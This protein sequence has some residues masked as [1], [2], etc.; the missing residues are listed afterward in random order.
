MNDINEFLQLVELSI[1]LECQLNF[2]LYQTEI[3]HINWIMLVVI[4]EKQFEKWKNTDQYRSLIQFLIHLVKPD[5]IKIKNDQKTITKTSSHRKHK[6]KTEG[7]KHS[8]GKIFFMDILKLCIENKVKLCYTILELLL[9][10]IHF[11]YKDNLKVHELF[12]ELLEIYTEEHGF[13]NYNW[14]KTYE[15][16]CYPSQQLHN[17]K[18]LSNNN[19]KIEYIQTNLNIDINTK[20]KNNNILYIHET[21]QA[22]VNI[23]VKIPIIEYESSFLIHIKGFLTEN[24]LVLE[25]IIKKQI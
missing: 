19:T 23:N 4:I 20:T 6:D 2:N 25:F 9:W 13:I 1:H 18:C 14:A 5:G 3:T 16:D 10:I 12:Q 22:K 7:L 8:G 17:I 21:K 15:I 24:K 11:D